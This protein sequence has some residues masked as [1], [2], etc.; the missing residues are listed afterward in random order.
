MK[1]E[2]LQ[3]LTWVFREN[4]GV[5]D[6]YTTP[7]GFVDSLL[8]PLYGVT[9]NFSSDPAMLTKVDLDPSAALRSAHSGGLPV[10]VHLGG[11]RAG[12]HPSRRVHR[13]TAAVQDAAAARPAGRSN[14]DQPTRLA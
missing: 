4:R 1:Q 9:G 10:V 14:D 8:S 13:P 5:K 6:F 7:V 3:F 2:V 11:Q 12:H